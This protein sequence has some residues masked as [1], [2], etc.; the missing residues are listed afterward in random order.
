MRLREQFLQ[1]A[2]LALQLFEPFGF[3]DIHAAVFGSP[4]VEAGVTEAALPAQVLHCRAR[5][6]LTQKP[7][8]LFFR[9]FAIS[10]VRHAPKVTNPPGIS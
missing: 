10:H 8:D 5:F 7:D 4:F 3:R 9:V 1:L 2:V 6:D